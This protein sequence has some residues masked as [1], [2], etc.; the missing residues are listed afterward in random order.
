MSMCLDENLKHGSIPWIAGIIHEEGQPIDVKRSALHQ[1][2]AV[3][4]AQLFG[5]TVMKRV[6]QVEPLY[7]A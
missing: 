3:G 5:N 7:C 1:F 2:V 6:L 4:N